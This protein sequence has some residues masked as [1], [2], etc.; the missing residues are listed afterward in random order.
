M[1]NVVYL[2]SHK[3]RIAAR[4]GFMEW[5]RIF[6]S[7]IDLD[8]KTRWADLPDRML[9]FFCEQTRE[10]R[11]TFYDLIMKAHHLGN[12]V[13]FEVQAYDR[14]TVLMNAYFFMTDQA[15]FECMRRLGW[16]EEIPRGEESIIEVVMDPATYEYK[17]LL[18]APAPTFS[19]PAYEENRKSRGIDQAALVRKHTSE[20]LD[21]F[22]K[23][24]RMK[25]RAEN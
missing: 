19:H 14:L 23:K 17:S 7:V 3:R 18:Q 24:V 13:D 21:L 6:G 25:P 4:R 22:R 16:V 10:S 20:A 15:R 1:A 2:E 12:G 8:E 5:R 9:L 11:Q